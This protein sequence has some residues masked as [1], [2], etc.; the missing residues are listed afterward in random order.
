MQLLAVIKV[1]AA[2][3]REVVMMLMKSEV[4][5]DVRGRR[6]PIDVLHPGG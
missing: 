3:A 6:F 4:L 2:M 5:G 1:K